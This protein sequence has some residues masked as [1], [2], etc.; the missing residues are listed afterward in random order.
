ML[1]I[2]ILIYVVLGFF[3]GLNW[4]KTMFVEAGCIGKTL[5]SA[6]IISLIIALFRYII[7]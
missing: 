6:W 4:V 7:N 1:F 5:A 2:V 3:F